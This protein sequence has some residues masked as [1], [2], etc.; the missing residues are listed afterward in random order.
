MRGIVIK[1]EARGDCVIPIFET[2]WPETR[3][4]PGE[5]DTIDIAGCGTQCSRTC[6]AFKRC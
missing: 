3:F 5:I 6:S 4:E 1:K 2:T